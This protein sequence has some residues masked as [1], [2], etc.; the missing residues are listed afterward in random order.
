MQTLTIIG[1]GIAGLSAGIYGRLNGFDTTI[2]EMSS[3]AGGVC[4]SWY[5]EGYS[6]NGSV[7]WVVGSAPGTDLYDMWHQLGVI[8]NQA[9]YNHNIFVAYR[10]I[11]GQEVNFYLDLHRLREHFNEIAPEDA[12]ATN[13]FIEA[14]EATGNNHFPLDRSFELLNA[15]DWAKIVA[16]NIPFFLNMSKYGGVSVSEFAN[17]FQSPVIRKALKSSWFSPMAMTFFLMQYAYAKKGAAGYPLGGSGAFVEK[18]LQRYEHLGGKI[19]YNI[20]VESIRIEAGKA[21]GIETASG[22]QV[23]SD[24]IIAAC[25][26]HTVIHKMLDKAYVDQ[27][28]LDAYNKL[29][30]FPALVYFSAGVNREFPEALPAIVGINIPLPTPLAVGTCKHDRVTF[31]LYTFDPTLA[32]KG[33]TLITA[34][35]DTDYDSWRTLREQSEGAYND[36][37]QRILAA[38]IAS[39]EEEFGEIYKYVEFTDLATP[40]TY[41]AWTGNYKGSYEGWLPTP[42]ASKV[43]MKTHFNELANFYLAGHWTA[44]GGGM[45][46]AAYSGRNA[47]QL[48]CKQEQR[49]FHT[50]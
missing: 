28:T 3:K 14:I 23:P 21:V 24:Y 12:A 1:G 42:E 40:L 32:P 31:Q 25:D 11:N 15:W 7:H 37:R 9:Y 17:K 26:G 49:H 47:V 34:M 5:R 2:Y 30:T 41:E 43:R 27:G 35:V 4:S 36:E 39:L 10:N 29:Q 22:A 16:G 8:E 13:E 50:H 44:P 45:P 6:V 46:P 48:I 20:R 33:K 19:H 38:L 18:L